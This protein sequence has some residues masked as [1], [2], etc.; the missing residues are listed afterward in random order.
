[1]KENSQSFKQ[2]YL[3]DFRIGHTYSN[4]KFNFFSEKKK[5][6]FIPS[7][8]Y[9]HFLYDFLGQLLAV[10]NNEKNEDIELIIDFAQDHKNVDD[11]ILFLEDFFEKINLNNFYFVKNQDVVSIGD[12]YQIGQSVPSLAAHNIIYETLLKAYPTE[13][14]QPTKMVYVSRKNPEIQ[15]R[16]DDV[17]KMED[18]FKNLGFEIFLE[19][20]IGDTNIINNIK[21]FRDVKILAGISGAGLANSILMQPGGTVIEIAVPQFTT[22]PNYENLFPEVYTKARHAF[23]PFVSFIKDHTHIQIAVNDNNADTAINKINKLGII[24]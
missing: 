16:I 12:F 9:Y 19:K 4:S 24:K 15:Q 11:V 17:D 13:L 3:A 14:K 2:S 1:M 6:R 7:R 5:F 20:D 18:F 23:N 8:N 21:Y 22:V 10:K